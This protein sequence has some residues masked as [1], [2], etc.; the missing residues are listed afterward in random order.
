MEFFKE[1]EAFGQYVER[2]TQ[3][4]RKVIDANDSTVFA[5]SDGLEG[6]RKQVEELEEEIRDLK[7]NEMDND[8]VLARF[9][10]AYESN[11]SILVSVDQLLRQDHLVKMPYLM[12]VTSPRDSVTP[13]ENTVT[14]PCPTDE[15]DTSHNDTVM[16]KENSTPVVSPTNV[17][18]TT[19]TAFAKEQPT[20][21]LCTPQTKPKPKEPDTGD[22]IAS[23]CA[24]PDMADFGISEKALSFLDRKS[25]HRN[26][27]N[28]K[29]DST[30]SVGS[31]ASTDTA[32]L[33]NSPQEVSELLSPADGG[34]SSK[35]DSPTLFSPPAANISTYSKLVLS[36]VKKGPNRENMFPLIATITHEEVEAAPK[37]LRSQIDAKS[38]NDIVDKL[39]TIVEDK[40][41]S[42]MSDDLIALS[43]LEDDLKLGR[44][45]KVIIL[46]LI[47]LKRLESV[48]VGGR[49]FYQ[50]SSEV[51][52]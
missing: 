39:N 27:R 20:K 10:Q 30:G 52:T 28:P 29:R 6:V 42:S 9:E 50:I 12:S 35:P 25:A 19:T 13:T 45:A 3:T 18:E 15:E 8:D 14:F 1:L 41:K 21:V 24:T 32:T 43:V 4:L 51:S 22:S 2:S 34:H 47:K 11:E 5:G 17:D 7:Q 36:T 37:Y 16:D 44:M 38:L 23:D 48:H 40:R 31:T 46:V 26:T 49:T 33:L